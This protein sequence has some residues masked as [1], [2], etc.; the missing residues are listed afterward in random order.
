MYRRLLLAC[1]LLTDIFRVSFDV[2]DAD[3]CFFFLQLSLSSPFLCSLLH[4]GLTTTA[5]E[6]PWASLRFGSIAFLCSLIRAKRRTRR[7]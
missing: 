7:G 1:L 4:S 3:S 5:L 2:D 6:V